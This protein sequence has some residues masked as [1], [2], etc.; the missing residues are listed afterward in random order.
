MKK[1]IFFIYISLLTNLVFATNYYCDPVNGNMANP[2]TEALP[3]KTLRNVIESN[4]TFAPGDIIYLRAGYHDS[5][6]LSKVYT[7][8]VYLKAYPGETPVLE[9]LVFNGAS[10][11]NIDGLTITPQRPLPKPAKITDPVSPFPENTLIRVKN[12]GSRYT[13]NIVITNCNAFSAASSAGWTANDWNTKAYNGIHVSDNSTDVTVDNC[14]FYNVNFGISM[15]SNAQYITIKNCLVENICGDGI[16]PSGSDITIEYNTVKNLYDVNENHYDMIQAVGST[17]T[18]LSNVIIRG[19]TLI[20]AT[21]DRTDMAL[22]PDE[23]Q[24]IGLFDGPYINWRIENNV[25][26]NNHPH[27]ISLYNGQNCIIANNTVLLNPQVTEIV[28][29]I[30]WIRVDNKTGVAAT[31]NIVIRNNIANRITYGA[32]IGTTDY[33]DDHNYTAMPSVFPYTTTFTD[34]THFDVSLK[35]TASNVIDQGSDTDVPTI[36]ITKASRTSP[37]DIGA[38]EYIPILPLPVTFGSIEAVVSNNNLTINWEA[39]I[40]INKH[41]YDVEA[42]YNG[43]NFIKLGEVKSKFSNE[44]SQ[45][46]QRYEFTSPLNALPVIS[47]IFMLLIPVCR[48]WRIRNIRLV[49]VL[50]LFTLSHVACNK[51]SEVLNKKQSD[52]FIRIAQTDMDGTKIFSKIIK[53]ITKN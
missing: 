22:V 25:V 31:S 13:N 46:I 49:L 18:P 12:S 9:R 8:F 6:T 30:P 42:S 15:Y 20:H 47:G 43:R 45:L 27:G 36:D 21:G 53:A 14:H 29:N 17:T 32:T 35:A 44:N 50:L 16:R 19:N 48:S 41:H 34:Y 28:G 3:W 2:G 39:L 4:K 5:V 37:F 11:W 40:E 51:S 33:T 26:F 38:Y 10:H 23:A 24:G 52:I 7:G 1:A